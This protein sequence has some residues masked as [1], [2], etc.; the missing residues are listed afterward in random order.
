MDYSVG[1]SSGNKLVFPYTV[2]AG[3]ESS[4]LRYQN[5]GT[6]LTGSIKDL[7][8]NTALLT[9]P[10]WSNTIVLDGVRPS[11][12]SIS[13]E[14]NLPSGSPD[15]CWDRIVVTFNEDVDGSTI[16]NGS[17]EYSVDSGGTVTNVVDDGTLDNSIIWVNLQDGQIPTSTT[18][19]LT[20]ESGGIE[21]LA[22]NINAST[23][24]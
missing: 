11:I 9:L 18:P 19:T 24:S 12:S 14:D 20:I 13:L 17:D 3:D 5:S 4:P 7:Q 1:L 22:G 10:G 8:G 21:D 16:E 23:S 6:S 2:A 15:G